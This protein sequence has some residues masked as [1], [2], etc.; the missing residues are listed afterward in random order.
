MYTLL[1]ALSK[2][3]Q[4]HY[5]SFK[6]QPGKLEEFSVNLTDFTDM[7]G[8]FKIIPVKICVICELTTKNTGNTLSALRSYSLIHIFH[9]LCKSSYQF[10]D[11]THCL[12]IGNFIFRIQFYLDKRDEV[13]SFFIDP[14][15]NYLERIK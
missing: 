15:I 2:N 1:A 7:H 12:F 11:I 10:L 6:I 13:L 5:I 3:T 4:K 14:G 8:F 9:L